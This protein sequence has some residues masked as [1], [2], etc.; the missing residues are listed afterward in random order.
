MLEIFYI[1]DLLMKKEAESTDSADGAIKAIQDLYD[2]IHHDVYNLDMR[3]AY[4][5]LSLVTFS[6]SF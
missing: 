4:F 2:V 5:Y 3:C 6:C 1:G